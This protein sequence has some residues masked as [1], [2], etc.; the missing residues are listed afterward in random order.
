MPVF[1]EYQS[2]SRAPVLSSALSNQSR[3]KP[4]GGHTNVRA[5][6]NA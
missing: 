1:T 4:G 6:L 3:V 5:S 2:A